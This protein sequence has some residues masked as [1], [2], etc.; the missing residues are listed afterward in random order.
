M[1]GGER[2]VNEV[3]FLGGNSQQNALSELIAKENPSVFEFRM[4]KVEVPAAETSYMCLSFK[5]PDI[6]D[7]HIIAADAI[8]PVGVNNQYMLHHLV[9]YVCEPG[10]KKYYKNKQLTILHNTQEM[11]PFMISI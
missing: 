9:A 3:T 1:H 10:K 8:P 7:G 5:Y 6:E 4:P 11:D 2:G